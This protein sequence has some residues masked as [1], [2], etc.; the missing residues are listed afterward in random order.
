MKHFCLLTGFALGLCGVGSVWGQQVGSPVDGEVRAEVVLPEA[1]ASQL[2]RSSSVR[3][4]GAGQVGGQG[5][6]SA[7]GKPLSVRTPDQQ[8]ESLRVG[9]QAMVNGRPYVQPTERDK[10]HDYLRSS[11]GLPAFAQSTVRALYGEARGKPTGWGTDFP[12]FMQREGASIGT[13]AING[14]VRYAGEE[15]F[16]EDLRYLPCHGCSA[17]H[18]VENALLAEITARH[19]TDG[20]RFF[21]LTP[22]VADFSGPI[23]MHMAVYPGN[24]SGPLAGAVSARTVF[25]TRIG[26]HLFQE[27]VLERRHK[28]VKLD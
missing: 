21:T 8:V 26:S 16:H 10:L 22:V 28:D 19:D 25:A 15:I 11:Y 23:L 2:Q 17:K 27:F 7:Q 12:G 14:S 5:A 13:T 18:K 24:A 6:D 3:G 9:R 1:P 20:H 4:R